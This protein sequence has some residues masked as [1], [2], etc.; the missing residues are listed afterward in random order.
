MIVHA[1][2]TTYRLACKPDV[3][4]SDLPYSEHVH[5]NATSQSAG[6]GTRHRDLQF[7]HLSSSL[8][9]TAG[10]WASVCRWSLIYSDVEDSH[11]MI[12]AAKA[13]G[14]QYCRTVPW[15]R[16]SMPQ[17]S[18]DRPAQGF[19]HL[20]VFA[21]KAEGGKHWNGPGSVTHFDHEAP[22]EEAYCPPLHHK[23]LR[24]D[25]KHKAE[26]PLD[27]LLDLVS[28][29]SDPGETILDITA[30]SGTTGRACS[31]LGRAFVGLEIDAAWV[32]RAT[33]RLQSPLNAGERERVRRWLDAPEERGKLT[34]P[35]EARKARRAADK[36]RVRAWLGLPAV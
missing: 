22:P 35:A 17:L 23:C 36:A 5:E 8:R 2:A 26:K 19:E 24:G 9:N 31:L 29:F 28:W 7:D 10:W 25:T 13:H 34:Q 16:W 1:D 18:G 6:G 11:R 33:V 14:A 12:A 30:G 4:I 3:M 15:V 32:H 27:Q 21:G 20:I